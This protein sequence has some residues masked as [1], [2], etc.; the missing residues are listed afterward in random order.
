MPR[1]VKGNACRVVWVLGARLECTVATCDSS[2][3]ES[4]GERGSSHSRVM[5]VVV[6]GQAGGYSARYL[7]RCVCELLRLAE[8]GCLQS[9]GASDEALVRGE[10][11]EC[12]N[13]VVETEMLR[14]PGALVNS[15]AACSRRRAACAPW[16]WGRW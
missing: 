12:A 13:E 7:D 9:G 2:E 6:A 8:G 14:S 16:A 1:G 10:K 4:G 5:R 11:G 15:P 3:V